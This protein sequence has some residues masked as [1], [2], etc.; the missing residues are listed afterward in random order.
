MQLKSTATGA[1]EF[2]PGPWLIDLGCSAIPGCWVMPAGVA[3]AADRELP[4]VPCVTWPE[5]A[6]IVKKKSGAY[7]C[8]R[9]GAVAAT[10]IRGVSSLTGKPGVLVPLER[11][12]GGPP[13]VKLGGYYMHRMQKLTPAEDAADKL[14]ALG[15]RGLRG[16]VLDTCTGLGYT[17]LGAAARG[18]SEVVTIELDPLMVDMQRANPWSAP[19]FA[20]P[21]IARFLGCAA[22]LLPSAPDAHFDTVVHDPPSIETAGML[23]GAAFYAQLRRVLRSGGVLY[24]YVGEP[25]AR[26]SVFR[27]VMERLQRA[28]FEVTKVPAS[29]GVRAV[30]R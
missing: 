16:R 6:R 17:A 14:G 30:A 13:T 25:K 4:G 10:K 22:G 1:A 21:K 29:Y 19:L 24:H 5:L 20:H 26:D 8:F 28:G 2:V 15:R 9:G 3:L 23:Y 7:Q 27:G 11:A 18:A 12:E